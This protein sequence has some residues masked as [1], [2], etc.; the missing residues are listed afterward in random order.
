MCHPPPLTHVLEVS[1]ENAWIQTLPSPLEVA[2]PS[3]GEAC[4]R[5]S[6]GML[7]LSLPVVH[8]CCGYTEAAAG[9]PNSPPP[10]PAISLPQTHLYYSWPFLLYHNYFRINLHI[11]QSGV[12]L[13][14]IYKLTQKKYELYNIEPY[15]HDIFSLILMSFDILCN[16]FI[17]TL[18]CHISYCYFCCYKKCCL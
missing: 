6:G 14:C 18:F 2:S 7:A 3:Q 16:F 4:G 8:L 13:H 9:L 11:Y 12:E 17:K 10:R 1:I 15:H 5:G